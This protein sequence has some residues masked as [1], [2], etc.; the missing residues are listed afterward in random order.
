[1]VLATPGPN[2]LTIGAVATTRGFA[3]TVPLCL[4]VA[5]GVGV[6]AASSSCFV[7]SSALPEPGRW[8]DAAGRIAGALLL[9]YLTW[10]VFR[11]AASAD[12]DG[13]SGPSGAAARLA[14][15]GTGLCTAVS[16]PVTAAYFAAEF[17][18][19]LGA[20]PEPVAGVV[21]VLGVAT[22]AP[23]PKAWSWPFS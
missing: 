19:P 10:G 20:S 14:G 5:C 16:N 12:D 7:L 8:G 4:G 9:L 23:W 11:G 1:V 13:V 2:M 21:A 22:A 18:G 6:L 15:F 17:S 3:G